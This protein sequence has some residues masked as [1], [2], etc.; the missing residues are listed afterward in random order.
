V[1][2]TDGEPNIRDWKD[3][4]HTVMLVNPTVEVYLLDPEGRLLAYDAPEEK[5]LRRQVDVEPIRRFLAQQSTMPLKGDD[6]RS[7]DGRKLFAAAALTEGSAVS[8]YVYAILSSERYRAVADTIGDSYM[9][10]LSLSGVIVAVVFAS[11]T[12]LLL[13]NVLTRRLRQLTRVV[14]NYRATDFAGGEPPRLG[15][16]D[17]DE[18]DR[19]ALAYSDMAARIGRQLQALTRLDQVR[20]ELIT[21]VS[22]DLR[23]PLAA[24]LGSIETLELKQHEFDDEQKRHYLDVARR[25]GEQLG[26]LVDQLF[27]LSQLDS[28]NL[29]PNREPFSLTD[30]IQDITVAYELRARNGGVSLRARLDPAVPLVEAD[31][32][33]IQ[34]V[35][36]NLIENALQ[37]TD[38]G[39]T[40]EVCTE[41]QRDQ[42]MISVKDTG[43]GIA[44]E[45]LPH[46]FERLYRAPD[47]HASGSHRTG[48]GLAIV[49]RVLDLH[50]SPIEVDS[51]PG[52]GTRF[53][54]ALP[55]VTASGAADD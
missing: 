17:G 24:M 43:R 16:E 45:D 23:T 8:G 41:R 35:F 29:Q 53:R 3:L 10:R 28:D 44:A 50:D 1:L 12:G 18:V 4:A 47:A 5:I 36:E 39:D 11:F 34:R 25:H 40:V 20:R 52:R 14:D 37:H 51:E 21:N 27:E 32:A 49:K 2:M 22:H 54:F 19:L 38:P 26:R 7:R 30:L 6:P 9:L 55:A 46:I 48:L 13:F 31:I 15:R 42:V 33:M